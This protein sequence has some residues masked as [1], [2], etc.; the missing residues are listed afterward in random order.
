MWFWLTCGGAIV[1]GIALLL[2]DGRRRER[3][4]ARDWQLVLTP[5][6]QRELDRLQD[7][8]KAKLTLADYV[9][10]R[11][12]EAQRR[13]DYGDAIELVDLGCQV[14]EYYTP[15][16]IRAL[17]AMAVLSRMAAAIA[18]VRPLR[19]KDFRLAQIVHLAQLNRFFHYLLVTTAERF[20]FRVYILQRGFRTL[21]ALVFRSSQH[22]RPGQ[23]P[24]WPQLEAA[25][26]DV[27]TLSEESIETFRALLVSLAAERRT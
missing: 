23:T 14:I 7:N 6:G 26:H 25:N 9:Y 2:L 10:E 16:M 21:G 17:G 3:A 15:T 1:S 27:V 13:G 18:P 20:R 19:P 12:F 24:D 8:V 5:K 22:G 11:A 4:I